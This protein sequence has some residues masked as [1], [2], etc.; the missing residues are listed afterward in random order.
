MT[1]LIFNVSKSTFTQIKEIVIELIEH[2]VQGSQTKI[3]LHR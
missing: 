2:R 3:E 1:I